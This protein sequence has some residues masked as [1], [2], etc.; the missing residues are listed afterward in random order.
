LPWERVVYED[1]Q[2]YYANR[3]TKTFTSRGETPEEVRE[4]LESE[5]K[6][7]EERDKNVE[8]EDSL[9]KPQPYSAT[10]GEALPSRTGSSMGY[11]ECLL[12]ENCC[13]MD[14]R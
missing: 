2:V 4:V 3:V 12:E 6:E 10:S 11:L 7:S 13:L 1:G 14:C 8:A 5:E 9:E